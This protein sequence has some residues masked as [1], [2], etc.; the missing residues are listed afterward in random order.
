MR[1]AI[2]VPCLSLLFIGPAS[3]A[4]KVTLTYGWKPGIYAKV[5]GHQ[6]Q[7]KRLG[8]QSQANLQMNMSYIMNTRAHKAGLQVDYLDVKSSIL[9]DNAPLQ[10]WMKNYME[11]I[12]AALPSYLVNP[13]GSLS[14]AT[15]VPAFREAMFN[16]L[17]GALN[18]APA[19]QKEQMLSGL[20]DVFSEEALNQ[21]LADDWNLLVG[22]W[23]GAELEDDGV[24]EAEIETPIPALGNQLVKSLAQIEFTGRVNCDSAD[25]T[26]ACVRLSY[27]SQTDAVAVTELLRKMVPPGQP[28]PELNISVVLDLE[29]V[30]DPDTLL[31]YFTKQT[32]RSTSPLETAQGVV[33]VTQVQASEFKYLYVMGNDG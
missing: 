26:Q 33:T 8:D 12:S 13:D 17:S 23:L 22:Q 25:Q 28:V 6:T 16:S 30:T 2:A 11:T 10:G 4:D 18:E 20:G 19:P 7:Q 9:S 3:A 27:H 21:Q 5:E 14:G 1:T 29:L 32:K 15:G 24:Y 31:P